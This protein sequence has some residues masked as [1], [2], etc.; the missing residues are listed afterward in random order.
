[1]MKA[2][3]SPRTMRQYAY[4]GHIPQAT[5]IGG[6]NAQSTASSQSHSV[7]DSTDIETVYVSNDEHH[8]LWLRQQN[9]LAALVADPTT[10]TREDDQKTCN[11]NSIVISVF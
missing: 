9:T 2:P 8:V 11:C 4:I 3:A 5:F 10:T 1:M 6:I 7:S